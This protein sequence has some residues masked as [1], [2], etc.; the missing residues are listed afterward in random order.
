L[1]QSGHPVIDAKLSEE[2][3]QQFFELRQLQKEQFQFALKVAFYFDNGEM[4][5]QKFTINDSKHRFALPQITGKTITNF[6][7]DP[8]TELLFEEVKN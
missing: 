4:S 6:Q 3:E 5:V 2:D 7:L 1:Y 8:N